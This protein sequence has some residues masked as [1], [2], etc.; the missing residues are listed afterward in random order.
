MSLGC[1]IFVVV[2]EDDHRR[3]LVEDQPSPTPTHE[4]T[5]VRGTIGCTMSKRFLGIPD[6]ICSL[7]S[8]GR[9]HFCLW[10]ETLPG[11][12]RMIRLFTRRL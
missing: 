11:R 2:L 12:I 10:L 9:D 3:Y 5:C 1:S 6:A 7:S 4:A 8:T